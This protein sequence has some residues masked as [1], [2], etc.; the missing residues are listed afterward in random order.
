MTIPSFNEYIKRS[1]GHRDY[2]M[3][4]YDIRLN[5]VIGNHDI[6]LGYRHHRDYVI[7]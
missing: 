5:H 6:T 3:Y 4:G 7:D 2:G 1:I